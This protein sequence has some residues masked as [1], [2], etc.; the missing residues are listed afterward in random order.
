MKTAGQILQIARHQKQLDLG[1]VSRITKIR[2]EFLNLIET[3]DYGKLPSGTVARGFIRNYS[4]FLDLNPSQLLAIFRRDF[5]EN[6]QGQIV[7]RGMVE[8]VDK[9]G[10]WTPKTTLF[11]G[12]AVIFTLFAAYLIFQYRV[13]T[14]PPPLELSKPP[15][16]AQILEDSVEVVG[17]TD[18]EST[19]SINGQLVAL[20]KGGRFIFR[21]TLAPGVNNLT[22]VATNKFNRTSTITRQVIKQ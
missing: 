18:P 19:I 2:P 16:N 8:P 3:D 6:H 10:F 11:A 14:G 15:A 12:L 7:P 5:V 22:I 17:S 4:E 9:P 1:E 20:E 21:V 13:L